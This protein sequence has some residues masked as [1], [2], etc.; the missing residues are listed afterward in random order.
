MANDFTLEAWRD[1]VKPYVINNTEKWG[2]HSWLTDSLCYSQVYERSILLRSPDAATHLHDCWIF[3]HFLAQSIGHFTSNGTIFAGR[4][5]NIYRAI[6]M[7]N[8]LR[9]NELIEK[10]IESEKIIRRYPESLLD[11]FDILYS[12]GTQKDVSNED[13][14][15]LSKALDLGYDETIRKAVPLGFPADQIGVHGGNPHMDVLANYVE[16]LR[17][18]LTP[19]V[20]SATAEELSAIRNGC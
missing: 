11:R 7:A 18:G 12:H 3:S 13:W 9:C 2:S 19:T 5:R 6:N 20:F 17:A 14:E 10:L 16:L 4:W 15:L 8:L 1:M